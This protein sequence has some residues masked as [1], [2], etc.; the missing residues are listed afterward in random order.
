MTLRTRDFRDKVK[1]FQGEPEFSFQPESDF[2]VCLR[3]SKE[4]IRCQES[5]CVIIRKDTVGKKPKNSAAQKEVIALLESAKGGKLVDFNSLYAFID[6]MRKPRMHFAANL[7]NQFDRFK[8][9]CTSLM[10]SGRVQMAIEY[11]VWAKF[12]IQ[13]CIFQ[14]EQPLNYTMIMHEKLRI[15]YYLFWIDNLLTLLMTVEMLVKIFVFYGAR[16]F[17]AKT[18]HIFDSFIVL[19]NLVALASRL[20]DL[21]DDRNLAR[22]LSP[23]TYL[24][25][26]SLLYVKWRLLQ[27]IYA[28]ILSGKNQLQANIVFYAAIYIILSVVGYRFMA[29]FSS[30]IDEDDLLAPNFNFATFSDSLI[31]VFYVLMKFEFSSI[32][33]N[34]LTFNKKND[35]GETMFESDSPTGFVEYLPFIVEIFL[36][37]TIFVHLFFRELFVPQ[38]IYYLDISKL[39]QV[40]VGRFHLTM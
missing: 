3:S 34:Y 21:G 14:I 38:L 31:T 36:L 4:Y 16:R 32:A 7:F 23:F 1:F 27:I 13:L 29:T 37:T 40:K 12:F 11:V 35:Q 20:F 28:A 5:K 30:D 8:E 17:F 2:S 26:L 15:Y 19:I 10:S 9:Q 39:L 18:I 24:R 25:I 6:E 33:F 22:L